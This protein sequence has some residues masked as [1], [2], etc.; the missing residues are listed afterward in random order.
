MINDIQMRCDDNW[1][2]AGQIGILDLAN[3]QRGHLNQLNPSVI[4]KM[5][6]LSQESYPVN[7]C[8]VVKC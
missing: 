8:G 2:V 4:K 1:I 5:T 7:H 3:V 6:L